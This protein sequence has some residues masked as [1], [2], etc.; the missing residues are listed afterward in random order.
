[1]KINLILIFAFF[2]LSVSGQK[3]QPKA[4]PKA[5]TKSTFEKIVDA[6]LKEG[7]HKTGLSAICP[8]ATDSTAKKIFSEYGAVFV[9]E[10]VML[11]DKCIYDSES[12]VQEFQAQPA[13]QSAVIGGVT[14]VLQ[15][16]AMEALKQA[17]AEAQKAG[18]NITPRGGSRAAARSFGDTVTFWNSRLIPG[19]AFWVRQK[20]ITAAQADAVKRSGYHQQLAQVLEWENDGI[21]FSKDLSKSILYSVAA[22]GASQH[23]FMLAL[24][25]TQYGSPKV[26][27]IMARHGW[28][29]TVAS[30]LPHFTYLGLMEDD[31]KTRESELQELGLKKKTIGGQ[32]FWVPNMDL[33]EKNVR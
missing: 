8:V 27:E 20:R 19:L 13:R 21:F 26:R 22:P 15:T 17:V 3:P 14:I 31:P 9:S 12:E 4:T 16:A 7:G 2:A 28:F 10:D 23:V 6:K 32:D 25:V 24:D 33:E 1:M 30:D 11:P 18:L 5:A 29:Q